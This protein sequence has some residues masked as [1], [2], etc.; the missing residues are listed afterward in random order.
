TGAPAALRGLAERNARTTTADG[1]VRY[2]CQA[3]DLLSASVPLSLTDPRPYLREVTSRN[4]SIRSFT[5]VMGRATVTEARR[6]LGRLPDPPLVGP[7]SRSPDL[8][9]LDLQPGEWVW[10]RSADEI[11]ET[12]TTK[13]RNR[14]LWFDTEMLRFCGQTFRVRA[15]VHRL[16]DERTG[17]M[18]E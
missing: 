4:V 7:S 11:R 18:L 16:V 2:R 3:T 17:R 15:L 13:G 10:V 8:P 5:R 14:G 12:L 1:E 9:T 6:K